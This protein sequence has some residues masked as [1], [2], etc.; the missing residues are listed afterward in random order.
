MNSNHFASPQAQPLPTR[1]R[2]LLAAL[3]NNPT[4]RL[5]YRAEA[6]PVGSQGG[7]CSRCLLGV[8]VHGCLSIMSEK[9]PIVVVLVPAIVCWAQG[10]ILLMGRCWCGVLSPAPSVFT[11]RGGSRLAASEAVRI[12]VAAGRWLCVS[13]SLQVELGTVLHSFRIVCRYPFL[14]CGGLGC[15]Y[16]APRTLTFIDL[17]TFQDCDVSSRLCAGCAYARGAS[18]F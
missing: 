4:R 13:C 17:F 12:T 6:A 14:R 10:S 16:C 7:Y 11:A 15:C 3:T 5:P 9:A 18:R 1:A 2:T 8:R